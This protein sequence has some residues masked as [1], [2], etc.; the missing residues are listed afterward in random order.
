MTKIKTNLISI[1]CY[2]P[3]L[4]DSRILFEYC[5]I[6]TIFQGPMSDIICQ[7]TYNQLWQLIDWAKHIPHF[8]SL[9]IED[10]VT[11]LSAGKKLYWH[12]AIL[13]AHEGYCSNSFL[14]VLRLE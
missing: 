8:T 10:Q 14:F 9:P 13:V 2:R 1:S 7:A 3:S 12:Q 11:L 5:S 6:I 4:K